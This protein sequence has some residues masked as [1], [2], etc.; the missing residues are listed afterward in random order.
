MSFYSK[1]QVIAYEIPTC[2]GFNAGEECQIT[3]TVRTAIKAELEVLSLDAQ[4]RLLRLI[5]VAEAARAM[6]TID[7]APNVLKIFMVPEFYFRQEKDGP[8]RSYPAKEKDAI[9]KALAT[10]FCDKRF[11]DWLFVFGTIVWWM[12]AD[13]YLSLANLDNLLGKDELLKAQGSPVVW[14]EAIV[15]VGGDSLT[16]F[17][18]Q[19]YSDYDDIATVVQPSEKNQAYGAPL[20]PKHRTTLKNLFKDIKS[21]AGGGCILAAGDNLW[22]G[23]EVCL[24]HNKDVLRLAYQQYSSTRLSAP[25][26][27]FQMLV[28]CGMDITP[29]FLVIE[30]ERFAL[31][32]DGNPSLG[33]KSEVQLYVDKA[34]QT[35]VMTTYDGPNKARWKDINDVLVSAKLEGA[36][37]INVD[38]VKPAELNM[39]LSENYPQRIVVYEVLDFCHQDAH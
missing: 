19:H 7:P 8:K 10:V 33:P 2:A 18:K 39:P 22:F 29:A 32:A 5:A 23:V 21:A 36:M 35:P 15:V 16:S 31:R 12:S 30:K 38:T 14:N 20:L 24:D 27:D 17:K 34:N 26:L 28:S 13:H 37:K 1:F 3:E 6:L 4:R 25:E 11:A 9:L